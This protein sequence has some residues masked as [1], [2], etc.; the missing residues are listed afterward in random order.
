MTL[1]DGECID[2]VAVGAG[3][4]AK[5]GESVQ[6]PQVETEKSKAAG[7]EQGSAHLVIHFL[8]C[9]FT[10]SLARVSRT[11]SGITTAPMTICENAT[12]GAW[13]I[14]NIRVMTRP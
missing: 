11:M 4:V 13:K 3:I 14:K 6:P 10:L 5:T 1:V 7:E 12:S 8:P 2:D 9:S